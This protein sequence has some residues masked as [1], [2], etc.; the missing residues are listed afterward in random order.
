M[1]A[2]ILAAGR[3]MRMGA[4]TESCPKPM[5]KVAGKTLLEHKFD[6]LPKEVD[7]IVLVIGYMGSYIH[8][9]YGGEY[10]SKKILYVEQDNITGGTADAL[11]QAKSILRGKFVV[12]MG[13]DIYSRD[14]V[15][16]CLVPP[17]GWV[18][19]VQESSAPRSG[20]NVEMDEHHR[21]TAITEGEHTGHGYIGTNLYVLDA[22][23]FDFPLVRKSPKSNEYGLPQTVVPAAAAL[24][25]PFYAVKAKCWIQITEPDDIAKAES[26]LE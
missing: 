26:M 10:G 2:V 19:L 22:R 20:G 8:D 11:W 25:I 9:A 6:A 24:G 5:L 4:L 14:D 16:R 7:E 15:E 21:I 23:L 17:D 12:M 18:Q 3:G 13:D 1:Q